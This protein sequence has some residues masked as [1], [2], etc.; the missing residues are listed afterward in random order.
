[1]KYVFITTW[2]S[3]YFSLYFENSLE[4]N[5]HSLNYIVVKITPQNSKTFHWLMVIIGKPS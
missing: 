5:K 3:T 2:R 4:I 1:M